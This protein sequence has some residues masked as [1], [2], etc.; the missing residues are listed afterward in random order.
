M[1]KIK[2]CGLRRLCEIE[3]ANELL[4]DYVGFVLAP[5]F[6]RTVT[7]AQA[8]ELRAA[9]SSRVC[10][11][12]VF[13]DAPVE[14]AAALLRG[15]VIDAAQLHGHEDDDYIARLRRKTDTTII[16]AFRLTNAGDCEAARRSPAD[17]LLLD[18]GTGTGRTFDWGLTA[19]VTRPYFLA[20]GLNVENVA[21]AIRAVRPWG[22]DVSSGIETD[23][24]KD[25]AK[26]AAFVAAVR[27]EDSRAAAQNADGIDRGKR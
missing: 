21:A 20:G 19:G 24:R 12:G 15:G 7:P 13:V 25:L 4:P 22:V 14:E 27:A 18:S 8:E 1:T 6:R 5:G 26:M 17:V 11:V 2:L 23:G 9:L 3:R 10:A 16:K